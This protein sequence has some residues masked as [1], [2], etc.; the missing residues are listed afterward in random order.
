MKQHRTADRS[1]G[2]EDGERAASGEWA[3]GEEGLAGERRPSGVVLRAPRE[4]GSGPGPC[5]VAGRPPPPHLL[6]CVTSRDVV[7]R[8]TRDVWGMVGSARV[9]DEAASVVQEVFLAI[10]ER[11]LAMGMPDDLPAVLAGITWHKIHDHWRKQARARAHAGDVDMD[12]LPAS[13]RRSPEALAAQVEATR[14]ADEAFASLPA[15]QAALIKRFHTD[16]ESQVEAA[17]ELGWE[18]STLR[19]RLAAARA[20]WVARVQR[21]MKGTGEDR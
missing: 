4:R 5:T 18:P 7:L 14:I 3:K 1:S 13:S 11:I 9:G 15:E 8:H 19:R 17:A 16:E 21:I 20:E 2:E 12:L 6:P 10:H